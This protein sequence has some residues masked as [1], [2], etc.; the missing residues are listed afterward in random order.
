MLLLYFYQISSI[1]T[2]ASLSPGPLRQPGVRLDVRRQRERA[3]RLVLDTE[4]QR[5]PAVDHVRLGPGGEE[6]PAPAHAGRLERT[7]LVMIPDEEIVA[8]A[9]LE[10]DRT[11]ILSGMRVRLSL[12]PG[13]FG[14]MFLSMNTVRNYVLI[15]LR[16]YVGTK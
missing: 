12:V 4:Q 13:M 2:A 7:G 15:S 16:F 9:I 1:S 14:C 5:P 3:R 8:N 10:G 11:S 6:G